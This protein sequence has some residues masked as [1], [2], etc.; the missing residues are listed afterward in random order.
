MNKDQT[1]I[2]PIRVIGVNSDIESTIYTIWLILMQANPKQIQNLN[3]QIVWLIE[4][5]MGFAIEQTF[6]VNISAQTKMG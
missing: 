2:I 1:Q 5:P 4:L 3:I 6:T